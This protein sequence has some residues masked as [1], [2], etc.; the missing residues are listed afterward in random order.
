[1]GDAT[2]NETPELMIWPS[3]AATVVVP[4]AIPVRSPALTV[5]TVLGDVDHIADVVT[6]CVD[7]SLYVAVAVN[8]IE[9]PA[10]TVPEVGETLIE[11]STGCPTLSVAVAVIEPELAVIV[12][13]PTPVP[14]ADPVLA[15][16]A[17]VLEEELQLTALVRFCVLP[18]L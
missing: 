17:V 10:V 2:W 6:F 15:M 7:S 18:S 16:V 3:A 8:W 11:T 12:A 14:V 1:M 5:A 9:L 13:L 4:W